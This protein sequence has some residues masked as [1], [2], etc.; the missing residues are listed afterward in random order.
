MAA[1]PAHVEALDPVVVV[2]AAG[3]LEVSAVAAAAVEVEG[4]LCGRTYY[5]AVVLDP[6]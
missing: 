3:S 5:W 4:G 6:L 1:A 2:V